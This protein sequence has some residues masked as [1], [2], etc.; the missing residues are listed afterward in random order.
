MT[1]QPLENTHLN[2]KYLELIFM[3][4]ISLAR[5]NGAYERQEISASF[6]A[7]PRLRN[8][9]NSSRLP[10]ISSVLSRL[11]YNSTITAS[12][13][14]LNRLVIDRRRLKVNGCQF[15][16]NEFFKVNNFRK[17][18]TFDRNTGFVYLAENHIIE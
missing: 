17:L 18:H 9:L 3:F 12:W 14:L 4:V 10:R 5:G 2:Y 1:E 11:P 8:T 13:K 6:S 7:T 16:T 15:V